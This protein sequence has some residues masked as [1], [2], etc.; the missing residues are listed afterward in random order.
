MESCRGSQKIETCGA[1]RYVEY[2]V[3][4]YHTHLISDLL[5]DSTST[6][7]NLGHT[8]FITHNF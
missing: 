5:V 3:S 1:A 6:S 4:T 8:D 2:E 7:V